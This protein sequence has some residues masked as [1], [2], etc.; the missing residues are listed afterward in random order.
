[1]ILDGF[2]QFDNAV[3]LAIG[4]GTQASTNVIDLGVTSGIPTSAN[5]GGARDL[6]IGDDPAMKLMVEVT[7]TFTSGGSATLSV[8]LQGS[9]D[10]GSGS[11]TGFNTWW[12][13]PTYALAT[14][15]AG[16]RLFDMDMPRPPDG[17][18]VPRFI[19]LLYTVGTT[20]FTAGNVSA[21]LVLDR[22][23]QMYQ[24]TDNAI[25]GGYVAGITVAN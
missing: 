16:S 10:N 3:S 18:A 7:T 11:P 5:G 6:G 8:A 15:N 20:N 17:L 4:A 2:L 14:L 12:V 19:R 1:M 9:T 24:S 25:M 13:S 22:D 23:D 21:Y